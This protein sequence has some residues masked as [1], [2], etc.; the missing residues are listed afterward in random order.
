MPFPPR[1]PR[2][3]ACGSASGDWGVCS[4][5]TPSQTG[6]DV[7]PV[8]LSTQILEGTTRRGK[9][10]AASPPSPEQ[11]TLMPQEGSQFSLRDFSNLG[12]DLEKFSKLE[13]SA[14]SRIEILPSG[15]LSERVARSGLVS[16]AQGARS[17]INHLT[18]SSSV[19]FC[20][21]TTFPSRLLM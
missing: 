21:C 13:K 6:F 4:I 18:T 19:L 1:R 15:G 9:E 2:S 20:P 5:G 8:V 14:K 16:L 7:L 10:G 17:C 3:K 12:L 11:F